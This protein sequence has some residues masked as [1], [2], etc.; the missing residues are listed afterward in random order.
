MDALNIFIIVISIVLAIVFK[1]FLFNRIRQW[2]DQDL[3]RSLADGNPTKHQFLQQHYLQLR[4]QK[5][6]RQKLSELLTDLA[7]EFE[8]KQ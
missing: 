7:A 8:Q 2:M 5:V 4:S 1:W 3:I 6:K